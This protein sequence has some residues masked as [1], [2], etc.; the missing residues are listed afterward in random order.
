MSDKNRMKH[1]AR[2]ARRKSN[3]LA[4]IAALD[5]PNSRRNAAKRSNKPELVDDAINSIE[6]ERSELKRGLAKIEGV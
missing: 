2:L 4:A 3:I 1:N 5:N 6:R